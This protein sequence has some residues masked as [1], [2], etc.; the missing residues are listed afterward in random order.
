MCHCHR[1][2]YSRFLWHEVLVEGEKKKGE[3]KKGGG[4]PLLEAYPP[5]PQ[6]PPPTISPPLTKVKWLKYSC[7]EM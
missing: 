3:E 4:G 6:P 2:F 1:G 7:S 5:P